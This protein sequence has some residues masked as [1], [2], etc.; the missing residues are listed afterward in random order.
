MKG[1]NLV[2]CLLSLFLFCLSPSPLG[3]YLVQLPFQSFTSPSHYCEESCLLNCDDLLL[4]T[5]SSFPR[6]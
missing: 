6:S 1:P 5:H 4:V 3:H 2:P